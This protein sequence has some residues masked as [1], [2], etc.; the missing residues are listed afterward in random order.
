MPTILLAGSSDGQG[1]DSMP[2]LQVADSL[3][4]IRWDVVVTE[5]GFIGNSIQ[6]MLF[7]AA[8]TAALASRKEMPSLIPGTSS[9]L[10]DVYLPN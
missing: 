3:G 7:S 4:T 1:G 8:Q 9:L 6:D 10:A 5:I 2:R